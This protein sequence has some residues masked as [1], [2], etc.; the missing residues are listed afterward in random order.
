M[1]TPP[2]RIF[3]A[4]TVLCPPAAVVYSTMSADHLGTTLFLALALAAFVA[5]V[6][7]T[8]A[9]DNELAPATVGAGEAADATVP[10]LEMRPAPPARL[11]GGPG[12]PAVA[13]LAAACAA[14]ALV[15]GGA[16]A[17][18]ALA[19]AVVAAVGWLASTSADRTGRTPNL[20]PIGIP[21]AGLFCI[22]ALMFLMSRILL[23][24]PEAASTTIAIVV[25]ALILASASFV[26]AR[27]NLSSRTV[28]AALTAA[29]VLMVGG[30][31]IAASVGVRPIEK[32]EKGPGPVELA[33]RDIKFD[34]AEIDLPA[35]SQAEIDFQN[36]DKVP[37]NVAIYD[38]PDFNGRATFQGAVIVGPKSIKYKLEAPKAGTYYFRCDIHPAMQGKVV[39]G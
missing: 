11:P 12:W 7:V 10:P 26:A 8:I 32:H 35:T 29:G 36:E 3:L 21:V 20:L 5:A 22:G 23:A 18:P 30:G 17:V 13:G 27:P 39:V 24:V 15:L 34:K 33:A 19:L 25:A 28:L 2:A 9:R 6:S 16:Y 31:L 38:N 1:I 37:H 14:V 4:I